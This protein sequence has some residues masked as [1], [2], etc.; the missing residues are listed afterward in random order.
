MSGSASEAS[1]RDASRWEMCPSAG[2]LFAKKVSLKRRDPVD[3]PA[4]PVVSNEVGLRRA[5]QGGAEGGAEAG[6]EDEAEGG[7][8]VKPGFLVSGM[9]L[10]RTDQYYTREG[11]FSRS[12][13]GGGMNCETSTNNHRIQSEEKYM[14][15]VSLFALRLNWKRM[16]NRVAG[17]LF[18][19]TAFALS[20]VLAFE[21]RFDFA[22]P[23]SYLRPMEAALG[24]WVVCPVGGLYRRQG[25]PG[26]LAL[27]VGL[28]C[29]AHRTGGFGRI[30]RWAGRLSS[31]C[32]AAW[33]SA[34]GLHS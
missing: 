11:R 19:G 32:S 1:S 3:V 12:G 15:P 14:F 7:A 31:I 6:A 13:Q 10:C 17:Y 29:G 34:F 16:R 24:V 23:A 27:H 8:A 18:D 33:D 25:G 20:T 9:R 21:L 26:K 5:E 4:L 22:V 2:R 30:G 28:R